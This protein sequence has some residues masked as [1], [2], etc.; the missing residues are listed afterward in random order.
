MKTLKKAHY[1]LGGGGI[2]ANVGHVGLKDAII[3]VA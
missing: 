2:D 1:W 3:A